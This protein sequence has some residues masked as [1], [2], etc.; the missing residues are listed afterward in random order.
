MIELW[1][2]YLYQLDADEDGP[3]VL[4]AGVRADPEPKT[5]TQLGIDAATARPEVDAAAE[6][7]NVSRMS[8]TTAIGDED[9]PRES[10]EARHRGVGRAVEA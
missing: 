5:E 9:G 10:E 8:G 1:E 7:R 3:P 4:P 2:T 6:E